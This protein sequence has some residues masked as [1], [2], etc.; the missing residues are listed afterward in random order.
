MVETVI[1]MVIMISIFLGGFI[2]YASIAARGEQKK[3]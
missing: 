2:Y 3:R 1:W